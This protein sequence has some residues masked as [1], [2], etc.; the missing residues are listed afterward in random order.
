M[1]SDGVKRGIWEVKGAALGGLFAIGNTLNF[2]FFFFLPDI[3]RPK[4]LSLSPSTPCLSFPGRDLAMTAQ[5]RG[6]VCAPLP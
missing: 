1:P 5:R 3:H 6:R 2:I 4:H